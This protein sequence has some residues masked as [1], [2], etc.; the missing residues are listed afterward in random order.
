MNAD[1]RTTKT[2]F[3]SWESAADEDGLVKVDYKLLDNVLNR[4]MT[5]ESLSYWGDRNSLP[6]YSLV[7]T[8]WLK[9]YRPELY[10]RVDESGKA[11]IRK[12]VEGWA[13]HQPEA[14]NAPELGE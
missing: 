3:T 12:L 7:L 4:P 14:R 5:L 6:N 9:Q 11:E 10:A 2:Q 1:T 8:A 13:G